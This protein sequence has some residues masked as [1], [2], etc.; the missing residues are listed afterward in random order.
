[1]LPLHGISILMWLVKEKST[2]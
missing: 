2:R 1:V